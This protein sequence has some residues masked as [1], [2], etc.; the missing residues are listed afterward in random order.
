MVTYA[1]LELDEEAHEVRRAGALVALSPT[2]FN[3]LRY[4]M[5][6]AGKSSARLRSWI[7]CGTTTSAVTAGSSSP[8]SATGCFVQRNQIARLPVRGGQA[9]F[10]ACCAR[11]FSV[12][13]DSR[14]SPLAMLL[15]LGSP[16]GW[17]LGGR[18][19]GVRKEPVPLTDSL[20][21]ADGEHP[22]VD[23]VSRAQP[24]RRASNTPATSNV[25]PRP[26][27]WIRVR[28]RSARCPH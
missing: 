6:N 5:V 24:I 22:W 8:I 25:A 21:A 15:D 7:G 17:T 12:R 3:L 2:E 23:T 11:S 9:V 4:L 27:R 10:G 19:L 18:D 28:T 20:M 1:D 14:V 13:S 26:T 16:G